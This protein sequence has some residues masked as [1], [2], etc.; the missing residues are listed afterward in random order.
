M[1]TQRQVNRMSHDERT[2]WLNALLTEINSALNLDGAGGDCLE[3]LRDA[4]DLTEVDAAISKLETP[5]CHCRRGTCEHDFPPWFV[6]QAGPA[7]RRYRRAWLQV[8]RAPA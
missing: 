3:A 4:L 5:S 8:D 7:L 1:M 6:A 2:S